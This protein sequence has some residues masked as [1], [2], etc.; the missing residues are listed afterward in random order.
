[1]SKTTE[2]IIVGTSDLSEWFILKTI[3]SSERKH[4]RS[5]IIAHNVD[6]SNTCFTIRKKKSIRHFFAS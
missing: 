4:T 6:D 5:I 1:M 3:V 2:K